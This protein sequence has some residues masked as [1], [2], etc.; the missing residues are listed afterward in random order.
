[1]IDKGSLKAGILCGVFIYFAFAFQT[2]AIQYT[3]ASKNALLTLLYPTI[4]AIKLLGKLL[5]G[6]IAAIQLLI[7]VG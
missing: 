3:T 5:Y 4:Q 2:V 6:G 1:M 7:P